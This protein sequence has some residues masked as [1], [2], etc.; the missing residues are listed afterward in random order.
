MFTVLLFEGYNE[1]NVCSKLC[2]KTVS[3]FAV[4]FELH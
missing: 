4:Y 1:Y 2:D 3:Q